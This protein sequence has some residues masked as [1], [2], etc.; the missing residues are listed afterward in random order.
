M[1]Q[2]SRLNN[3]CLIFTGGLD[4][5]GYGQTYFQGRG[6]LCHRL[7]AIFFLEL[8]INDKSLRALHK[9]E[10]TDKAC[11]TPEHLYIGTHQDNMNDMVI[12]GSNKY[13]HSGNQH[14]NQTHCKR[15]HEFTE[16]NTR[17]TEKGRKCI[18]CEKEYNRQWR[19]THGI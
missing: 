3:D 19:E 16:E 2:R 15:G 7:S 4:K 1:F 17:Y 5:D 13:T 18:Q 10:C 8:D 6:Y 14:T 9:I 11:W 12:M